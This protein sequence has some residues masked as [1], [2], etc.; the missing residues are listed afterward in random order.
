MS[1]SFGKRCI[2][3][4]RSF[5][6]DGEEARVLGGQQ[7]RPGNRYKGYEASDELLAELSQ[8]FPSADMDTLQVCTPP[9][10]LQQPTCLLC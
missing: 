8:S 2:A 9:C 6:G 4:D 5:A 10:V 7:T 1:K 3:V